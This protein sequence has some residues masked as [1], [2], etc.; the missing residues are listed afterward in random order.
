[1][2]R[3]VGVTAAT[4]AGFAA[5]SAAVTVLGLVPMPEAI[6]ITGLYLAASAIASIAAIGISGNL[7]VADGELRLAPVALLAL[8]GAWHL[9]TRRR[10][11]SV[12]A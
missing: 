1:M 4:I 2:C 10:L 12:A 11:R 7:T 8:F 5:I 3:K 9:G 6:G